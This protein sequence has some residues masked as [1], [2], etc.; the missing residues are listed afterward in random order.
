[1]K[2]GK[3]MA[4]NIRIKKASNEMKPLTQ[5]SQSYTLDIWWV[6]RNNYGAQS[7][8]NGK[9]IEKAHTHIQ[10]K[11]SKSYVNCNT[12]NYKVKTRDK[13]KNKRKIK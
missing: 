2:P 3:L 1:M 8:I 12:V 9:Q 11:N 13:K 4:W 5:Y 10:R 6:K 7:E